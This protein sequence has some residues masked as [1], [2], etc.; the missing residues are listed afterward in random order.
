VTT[1]TEEY[2]IVWNFNSEGMSFGDGSTKLSRG[3]AHNNIRHNGKLFMTVENSFHYIWNV[4][5]AEPIVWH[6]V[7]NMKCKRVLIKFL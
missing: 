5:G 1:G 3:V 2:E 6:E 4:P 7:Y